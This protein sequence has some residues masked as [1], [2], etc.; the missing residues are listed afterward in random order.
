MQSV[1]PQRVFYGYHNSNIR[2][3]SHSAHAIA[4][5]AHDAY[6]TRLYYSC[7][8]LRSSQF[9]SRR[10]RFAYTRFKRNYCFHTHKKEH[11]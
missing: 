7:S 9:S 2:H 4:G 11:L 8:V 6:S 1:K 10:Q 5:I 3:A